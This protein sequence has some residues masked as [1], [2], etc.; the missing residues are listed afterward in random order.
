MVPSK[1]LFANYFSFVWN[2]FYEYSPEHKDALRKS[3]Q[4]AVT[5]GEGTL[6]E[7]RIRNNRVRIEFSRGMDTVNYTGKDFTLS[8]SCFDYHDKFL[9]RLYDEKGSTLIYSDSTWENTVPVSSMVRY[10]EPGKKYKWTITAPRAGFIKKRLLYYEGGER[11]RSLINSWLLPDT[12]AED[13][14]TI[15]FRT[16]Y[17]LERAHY[18]AEALEFYEK[19]NYAD[20]SIELYRDQLIRFRN[21]YWI[22]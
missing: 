21:E 19:A 6:K 5:R 9:F 8:W 10:L 11:V 15:Y 1:G 3:N 12:Y 13:S 4:G 20:P 7:K 17:M 2:Q 16:A 14:A 22:R 18:P